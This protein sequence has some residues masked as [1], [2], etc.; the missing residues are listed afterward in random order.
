MDLHLKHLKKYMD[1]HTNHFLY[2]GPKYTKAINAFNVSFELFSDNGNTSEIVKIPCETYTESIQEGDKK[3][4]MNS[5]KNRKIIQ[6]KLKKCAQFIGRIESRIDELKRLKKN[7][8]KIEKFHLM[9]LLGIFWPKRLDTVVK[10]AK[11]KKIIN[12]LRLERWPMKSGGSTIKCG[13]IS[14]FR[15]EPKYWWNSGVEKLVEIRDSLYEYKRSL[16][17]NDKGVKPRVKF[18]R[19]DE[20]IPFFGKGTYIWGGLLWD[21]DKVYNYC[22]KNKYD[23]Y[24]IDNAYIIPKML[25]TTN[26][27]GEA[28]KKNISRHK[29]GLVKIIKNGF[30]ASS[31]IN[32]PPDR[33]YSLESNYGKIN[34]E[35]SEERFANRGHK[36]Y[37]L[38]CPPSADYEKVFGFENWLEKTI[39]EI[40][41]YTNREIK[42]REKKIRKTIPLTK[43]LEDAYCTVAPAS[44]VSIESIL[45]GV[46]TFCSDFSPAA[47][48]GNLDLSK[49]NEPWF[50][51]SKLIHKWLCHLSYCQFSIDEISTGTAWN[52]LNNDI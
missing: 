42:I 12:E 31:L 4:K 15:P 22:I 35:F 16:E 10:Y 34:W 3:S 13:R 38:I 51:D 6:T 29:F 36:K 9:H 26:V 48:V 50:P 44:G 43:D 37:I 28:G 5:L 8:K 40:K 46:P 41:K 19:T 24:W 7:S 32:R 25:N 20:L 52:I 27:S 39:K 47:P 11:D 33:L 18:R 17:D 30:H 23:Y 45:Y 21:T 1:K 14:G 49:I 2:L